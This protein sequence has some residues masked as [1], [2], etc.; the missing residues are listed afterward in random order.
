MTRLLEICV[1]SLASARSAIRGGADR[2][3]L[4]S[5]LALGG[6]TPY[7]ALLQ[8]IREESNIPIR[9]L[10]RSRPGDFLYSREEI[11]LMSRQI[12]QLRNAGADGFVIG[13][14]TSRGELDPASMD[15]LLDEASGCGLTL[16]R[17]I[18]VSSD[19]QEVYLLAAELG[20]DTVLTSGAARNCT[21]GLNVL[22]ALLELRDQ[23]TGPEILIGSGVNAGNIQN[24]LAHLPQ[25]RA[26]HASC[27]ALIESRMIFRRNDVPMGIPELDEWHI[28]QTCESEVRELKSFLAL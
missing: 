24:L 11:D 14:L 12:R 27:K 10:I 19:P 26:F 13:C 22:A 23:N 7:T 6:L 16:H 17:C 4:C 20:I 2:L 3:E 21:S 25:A 28:Q 9:C 15:P 5:A 8:Q 18:D 1:D